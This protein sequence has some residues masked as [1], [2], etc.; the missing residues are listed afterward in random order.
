MNDT[1]RIAQVVDWSQCPRGNF[2][3]AF[4]EELSARARLDIRLDVYPLA[5][6]SGPRTSRPRLLATLR[7]GLRDRRARRRWPRTCTERPELLVRNLHD[8]Q[9]LVLNWDVVNGDPDFGADWARDW[10]DTRRPEILEWVRHRGGI[11]VCEGQAAYSVPVQAAY[12]A[13]VGRREVRVCGPEDPD[14]PQAQDRRMGTEAY[15]T[16]RFRSVDQFAHLENLRPAE[17]APRYEQMFPGL[18]AT[19]LA[20]F[21]RMTDWD[22]LYRGWFATT[23]LARPRFPWVVAVRARRRGRDHPIVKA[24]RHGRG[25]IFLTTMSLAAVRQYRLV[26]AMLDMR[27]RSSDMPQPARVPDFLRRHLFVAAVPVVATVLA[28]TWAVR[29]DHRAMAGAVIGLALTGGAWLVGTGVRWAHR[30]G[31]AMLGR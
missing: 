25:V 12:D 10:V 16:K 7:R 22:T 2:W 3:P 21:L 14:R 23:P 1:V 30:T 11:L 19:L 8:T 29:E 28:A 24:A 20:S 26:E 9:V 15:V 17:E 6:R 27:G 13:V 5:D 18:G 4:V 31:R